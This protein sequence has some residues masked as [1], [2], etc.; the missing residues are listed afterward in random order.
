MKHHCLAIVA[1]TVLAMR[2]GNAPGAEWRIPDNAP[3][4]TPWAR[5]VSPA[6]ALPEYPRPQMVRQ[7]WH[8]LNGLW[9]YT[10]TTK[11]DEHVP[12]RFEGNILVPYPIESALSGV[13]KP[14]RPSERLWYRRTFSI[15]QKWRDGR[16]LLHF[17][18]VDWE[19]TVFVNGRNL[20]SH[21]GGY[22]PFTFDITAALRKEDQQEI[23]VSVWDPTDAS[24]QLRGKQT[25]H[26]GGAAYTAC[27]GIW[28]TVWL[29]PVPKCSVESLHLI[30]DVA[31]G[32]LKVVVDARTLVG[33]TNV[34]IVVSEGGRTVSSATGT[35]G[36]ELTNG[37]RENLAWH[38][39]RLM[40]V[41]T[42]VTV[43]MRD[44]KLWTPVSPTLYDV[45][46][47]LLGDDGGPLDSVTSYVGM[48]SIAVG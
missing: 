33:T 23:T 29:E 31:S 21:R 7:R 46:V 16:I 25:L 12:V 27:S 11:A 8:N 1:L 35:L 42:D 45:T 48:R 6:S 38:K 13:M 15:P 34:R 28:Q 44:A 30:P 40:W 43:S 18:A 22:D 19:T 36:A 2:P 39:A 32:T 41:T 4:L 5:E 9:Q 37:V 14:L 20:G 24:W 47:Q 17:G 10:V 26:P 3:L